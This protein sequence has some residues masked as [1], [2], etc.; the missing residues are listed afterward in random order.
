MSAWDTLERQHEESMRWLDS[1][2]AY[3]YNL[4]EKIG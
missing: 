1:Y 4:E 3:I 2:A